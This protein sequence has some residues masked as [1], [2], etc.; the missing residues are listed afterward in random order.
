M[1]FELHARGALTKGCAA[2]FL[3]FPYPE[4]IDRS[5][6]VIYGSTFATLDV[7]CYTVEEA[8]VWVE[9][10]QSLLTKETS[11]QDRMRRILEHA[12]KA[13]DRNGDERLNRRE[14][15]N[16]LTS[17]NVRIPK[18]TLKKLITQGTRG[19]AAQRSCAYT[20]RLQPTR[21]A[22]VC[23]TFKSSWTFTRSSV[24]AKRS[25]SSSHR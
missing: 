14:I 18:K 22:T 9:E 3:H 23:W 16:L 17:L 4:A 13:A 12:F 7:V 2:R 1:L 15:Y 25:K 21:M 5:F 19:L 10:L 6:S 20:C 11:D 8:T 24:S